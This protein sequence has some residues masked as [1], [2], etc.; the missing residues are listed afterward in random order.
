MP[1]TLPAMNA[2]I[3]CNGEELETYDVKQ[4]G[5]SM[6]T[7]FVASEAGKQF[8]ITF[9]NKS[10]ICAASIFLHVDGRQVQAMCLRPGASGE[11]LGPYNTECSILPLKFQE[12]QLVDPDLEDAPFA[13]EMGTIELKAYRC[14][15]QGPSE[16]SKYAYED[17]H[18]GRVSERSK[19]AGWHHVATGD[20]IVAPRLTT[21]LVD[22]LDPLTGPPHAS[23]KI[24][25]RPRELLRAQGIIPANDVD[26]QGSPVNN[27]K[28]A[29][30][31]GSPGPSSSRLK[32]KPVKGE[33]LSEDARAQRMQALQAELAA[34]KGAEQSSTGT[35]VKRELRS[36][37]PIVVKHPGE[38][39]DLT[40]ED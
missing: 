10:S 1:L 23:V 26:R 20:E 4:E 30:E 19:K 31:D 28:R 24:F 32:V 29:R 3:V 11:F 14:Q 9:S 13:P 34:L 27:K 39:V 40:L 38:V 37:S 22:Y 6:L 15:K 7:A 12:L 33:E 21:V 25:Y 8:K 2:A 16:S 5:T 17:L 35:S 36:P 18:Q